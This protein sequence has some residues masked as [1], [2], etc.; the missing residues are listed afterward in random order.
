MFEISD[1]NIYVIK[2]IKL[3]CLSKLKLTNKFYYNLINFNMIEKQL[4][5]DIIDNEYDN[6][7]YQINKYKYEIKKLL[8]ACKKNNLT[9][10]KLQYHKIKKL[11][12]LAFETNY[13]HIGYFF[14][15]NLYNCVKVAIINKNINLINYLTWI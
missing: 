9:L 10:L 3:D 1:L 12:L 11:N 6:E 13:R 4:D 5:L 7:Y 8:F 14:I 15:N 2:F